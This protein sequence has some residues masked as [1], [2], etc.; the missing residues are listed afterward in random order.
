MS[1]L[2]GP[3]Y[4]G[5][6]ESRRLKDY[7]GRV[8]YTMTRFMLTRRLKREILVPLALAL[9]LLL[10]A[11]LVVFS[12]LQRH[13]AAHMV[14]EELSDV[15]NAFV[16]QLQGEAEALESTLRAIFSGARPNGSLVGKGEARVLV[17]LPL[18]GQQGLTGVKVGQ[19]EGEAAFVRELGLGPGG[20]TLLVTA[21]KHEQGRPK[22][23]YEWG[24]DLG[25]LLTGLRAPF[26]VEMFVLLEK[27]GLDQKAW[28]SGEAHG[29]WD[30][31]PSVVM[32]CATSRLFPDR[33][34]EAVCQGESAP[35]D[36]HLRFHGRYLQ[37]ADLPLK[38]G[39]GWVVGAVVAIRDVTDLKEEMFS[40]LVA[41]CGMCLLVGTAFFGLF[42]RLVGA[43]ERKLEKAEEEVQERAIRDHLTG[44]YNRRGF[45]TLADQQLKVAKRSGNVALLLYA[46]LDDLK[47]INDNLG[48]SVGDAAIIEAADVLRD[49]FREAD[50]L[51]RLGGDEFAVLALGG[52]AADPDL[53][54]SRLQDRIDERNSMEKRA[55]RLSMSSGIARNDPGEGS[56]V[57]DL[58]SFADASMYREKNSKRRR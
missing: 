52:N 40:S 10:V 13:H 55:Y 30:R 18:P 5:P 16:A 1:L 44:L 2:R 25:H 32:V 51:G 31:F 27:K 14:A 42:W 38:D 7:G 12:L 57:E 46:D 58:I 50:I 35:T 11:F 26:G 33:L 28:E 20:L 37:W 3:A 15:K 21:P 41:A 17:R 29:R 56:S 54:K 9:G 48:H 53:L 22:G 6:P 8:E 49:V 4:F 19:K 23:Y 45:L 36:G 34:A 47:R 43:A 24:E 39:K